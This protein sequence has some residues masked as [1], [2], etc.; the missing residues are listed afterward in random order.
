MKD[1]SIP[2]YFSRAEQAGHGTRECRDL[3]SVRRGRF[4]L[5]FQA[6]IF[7]LFE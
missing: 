7:S 5:I 2:R 3:D 6:H 4:A 1:T